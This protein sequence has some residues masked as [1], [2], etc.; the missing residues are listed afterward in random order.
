MMPVSVDHQD[1]VVRITDEPP[2]PEA[3]CLAVGALPARAHLLMPLPGEMVVQ[4]RQGDVG[5]QR[6]E[7]PD[8]RGPCQSVFPVSEFGEDPGFQERLH[9][10]AH[11]LILDPHPETIHQSRMRYL[12]ETGFDI[13]LQYPLVIAG[14]GGEEVDLGNGV[15]CAPVRAEPVR[16]RLEIRLEDGLEHQFQACLDHAVG[17][18]GNTE[19]PEVPVRLRY[20]HL[21]YLNRREP[22]RLQ[23]V[24]DLAQENPDPDPGF[25]SGRSGLIDTW[26]PGAL[27][28]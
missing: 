21:P 13:A 20:H 23:R 8:L 4:R 18:S 19:F 7:N 2:A 14:P 25:D 16:A 27:I 11:T 6:R 9:Q 22:A 28:G 17:D 1:E 24:A 3:L 12:I 26:S 5:E 10:R 15:L